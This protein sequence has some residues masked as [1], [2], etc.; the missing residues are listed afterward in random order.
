MKPKWRVKAVKE[1]YKN[2]GF[3]YLKSRKRD[4]PIRIEFI[5]YRK[6]YRS[7]EDELVSTIYDLCLGSGHPKGLPHPIMIA[8]NYAKVHRAD[9]QRHVK[10]LLNELEKI[11][12]E[13][14]EKLRKTIL[15]F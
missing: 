9:L 13:K 3:F 10:G 14:A 5:T 4:L 6:M 1:L 15:R 2:L 7:W 11:D 8:D 12:P